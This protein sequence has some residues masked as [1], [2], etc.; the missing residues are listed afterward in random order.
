MPLGMLFCLY[1]SSCT[2]QKMENSRNE[3]DQSVLKP[4]LL[5]SDCH[6]TYPATRASYPAL[7]NSNPIP[8]TL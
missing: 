5:K 7:Q 6:I 8:E 2:K 4:P 1:K 3:I